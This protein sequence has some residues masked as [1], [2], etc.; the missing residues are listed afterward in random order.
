VETRKGPSRASPGIGSASPLTSP[1]GTHAW[2]VVFDLCSPDSFEQAKAMVTGLL[3]RV[4][5]EPK[6]KRACPV[7]IVLVGNKYDLTSGGKHSAVSRA[8][9]C[10]LLSSL[11]VPGGLVN[12]L[13]KQRVDDDLRRLA[14][15][16]L[17]ARK[18]A[19]EVYLRRDAKAQ[20]DAEGSK[21]GGG[22]GGGGGGAGGSAGA[23]DLEEEVIGGLTQSETRSM[24]RMRS[25][26]D[27]TSFGGTR[28]SDLDMLI[29]S[30]A[31]LD[32]PLAQA[33]EGDL[34][35]TDLMECIYTCPALP[36]KYV[37][38]SCKTNRQIHVLERILMRSMR[39]LPTAAANEGGRKATASAGQGTGGLIERIGDFFLKGASG[40][41]ILSTT[42]SW[43]PSECFAPRA[44]N[45]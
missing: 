5:Y 16:I 44:S 7:T 1:H 14:A 34:T 27:P 21:G 6:A 24:Q 28:A 4:G 41:G 18:A 32:H 43:A 15:K 20:R 30:L 9:I 10:E 23:V 12:Q 40:G 36:V 35:A 22:G 13:K 33:L 37:E 19:E 11:A 45:Q 3:D 39:L 31:A 8:T 17:Q 38:V 25:T 26:L 2:L 29:G 42:G